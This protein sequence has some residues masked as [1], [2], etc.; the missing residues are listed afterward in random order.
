MSHP[1]QLAVKSTIIALPPKPFVSESFLFH[2]SSLFKWMTA[3]VTVVCARAH[4]IQG[5]RYVGRVEG[6]KAKPQALRLQTGATPVCA[7]GLH[8]QWEPY[9]AGNAVLHGFASKQAALLFRI[10][11][12]D[13][14]N[15]SPGIDCMHVGLYPR[16]VM[17][18]SST[19]A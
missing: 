3:I 19:A 7:I 4:R 9:H 5:Y 18:L 12:F 13:V 17:L 8:S 16:L 14:R 10:Q 15:P 1:H 11:R 6:S 2:S